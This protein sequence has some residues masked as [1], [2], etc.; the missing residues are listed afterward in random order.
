M[1]SALGLPADADLA[2]FFADLTR[3]I[4]LPTTLRAVGVTREKI[5][6]LAVA[7]TKDFSGRTNPRPADAAAYQQL[8]EESYG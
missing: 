2:V 6:G 3:R 1:R 5:A 4:G 8:Y 7:A